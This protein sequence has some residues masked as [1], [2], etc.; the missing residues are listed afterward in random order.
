[1]FGHRR[2]VQSAGCSAKIAFRLSPPPT[3][4]RCSSPQ[5]SRLSRRYGMY[6]ASLVG[7]GSPR[8][9]R[10]HRRIYIHHLIHRTKLF[11]RM[12]GHTR[13]TTKPLHNTPPI[14]PLRS[15]GTISQVIGAR[16]LSYLAMSLRCRNLLVTPLRFVLA[17]FK[18]VY[19]PLECVAT[20]SSCYTHISYKS[21]GGGCGTRSD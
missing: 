21:A 10:D 5:Y 1:M 14:K 16:P 2:S 19:S 18:A 17:Y 20:T 9:H 6:S 4:C 12:E 8:H 11:P 13:P 3:S 15:S 7:G